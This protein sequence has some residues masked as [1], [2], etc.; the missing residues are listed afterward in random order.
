M[1]GLDERT[2]REYVQ[3]G[4]GQVYY[5]AMAGPLITAVGQRSPNPLQRFLGSLVGKA[6]EDGLRQATAGNIHLH[7]AR[8]AFN[9][10]QDN[11]VQ[12]GQHIPTTLRDKQAQAAA[13]I[14]LYF[15]LHGQPCGQSIDHY[16][17]INL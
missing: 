1:R 17:P 7:L 10:G 2:A 8:Q 3:A 13:R 16:C 9:A 6:D 12:S 5:G 15:Q 11:T 4:G 14:F